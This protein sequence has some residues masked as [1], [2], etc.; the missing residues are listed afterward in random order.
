MSGHLEKLFG[1]D[2]KAIRFLKYWLIVL[3]IL[4]LILFLIGVSPIVSL[5]IVLAIIS[6]YPMR[7]VQWLGIELCFF[8]TILSSMMFGVAAG[9]IVGKIAN[10][11]GMIF[12]NQVDHTLL[13]DF[14]ALLSVAIISSFFP[15][16]MISIVGICLILLYHV[17]FITYHKFL[18]TFDTD[19]MLFV[20][21]N[22]LFN[23]MVFWRIAP[24]V[25]KVLT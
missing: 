9:I 18:D 12:S 11:T 4:A 5:F 15:I 6:M 14:I 17:G 24:Y 21:S 19:N 25:V 13:Y 10:T 20:V 16:R 1:H 8:F 22:L 7:F 2:E 3:I 23:L